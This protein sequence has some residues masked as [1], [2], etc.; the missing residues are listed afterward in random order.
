MLGPPHCHLR[1][2]QAAHFF[3]DVSPQCDPA[4]FLR[5]VT[6]LRDWHAAHSAAAGGQGAPPPL[7]INTCGWVK[8]LGYD[9]LVDTLRALPLT[10]AVHLTSANPRKDLPEGIFWGVEGQPPPPV[11]LW[12]VPGAASQGMH[13][14]GWPSSLGHR[15]QDDLQPRSSLSA[16]DLRGL[17]WAAFARACVAAAP[18]PPA[19]PGNG[20][21][22][23]QEGAAAEAEAAGEVGDLL[24]AT[25]PLVVDFAEVQVRVLHASVPQA[26]L[27]RVLNS[28]IVGLCCAT[29]PGASHIYPC[30][31]LP[32]HGQA[33]PMPCL[34]LGIV[35]AVD[36]QSGRIW[37][38]TDVGEEAVQVVD[39]LQVG[40]LELPPALL[41]TGR[42]L[43]PYLALHSLATAGT[44]AG[45]S[46]SRNNLLRAGQL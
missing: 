6:S 5:C 24:A 42:H 13:S 1:P 3:G 22:A 9:V 14:T 20:A 15:H 12:Q 34:G 26:E 39:C 4:Y 28:A 40:R 30:A 18:P 21:A 8:G 41:Q 45:A 2:P 11:V 10:H 36:A 16:V 44:G 33:D 46:K 25:A 35:R 17:L 27:P 29:A 37:V 23:Q 43:S 32:Q 19:T 7:V 38:L 31:Q